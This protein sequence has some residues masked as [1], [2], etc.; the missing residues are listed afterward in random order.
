M[1]CTSLLNSALGGIHFVFSILVA[2]SPYVAYGI[3]FGII[4]FITFIFFAV[5]YADHKLDRF[6]PEYFRFKE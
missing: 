4:A 6:I 5:L 2:V 3:I 1:T